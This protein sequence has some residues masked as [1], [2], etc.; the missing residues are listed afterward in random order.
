MTPMSH[1][2]WK[3]K[4]KRQI[5]EEPVPVAGGNVNGPQGPPSQRIIAKGWGGGPPWP[6]KASPELLGMLLAHICTWCWGAQAEPCSQKGWGGTER[7]LLSMCLDLFASKHN[8]QHS[9]HCKFMFFSLLLWF[10]MASAVNC[11]NTQKKIK[12]KKTTTPLLQPPSS[13]SRPSQN[14]LLP[15]GF[16]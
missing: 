16:G 6:Q 15:K 9:S 8:R 10:T 12:G 13:P 14:L 2:S 5:W 11:P 7:L 1:T 4:K 3:K